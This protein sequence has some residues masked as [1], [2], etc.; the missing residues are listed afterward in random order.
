MRDK[1]DAVA[2]AER[3]L[4][5]QLRFN[6]VLGLPYEVLNKLAE[7]GA[8]RPTDMPMQLKHAI[9]QSSWYLCNDR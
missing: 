5:Y 2:T 6:F 8:W 9:Y 7:G 1:A 4:M 3:S